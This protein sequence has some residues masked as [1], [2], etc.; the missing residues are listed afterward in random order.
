MGVEGCRGGSIVL[1]LYRACKEVDPPPAAP[2]STELLFPTAGKLY[3]WAIRIALR[4]LR[5]VLYSL[6]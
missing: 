2:L 4:R 1:F 6:G 3:F 5:I